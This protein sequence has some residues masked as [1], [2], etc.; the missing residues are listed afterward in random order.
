MET[1]IELF[2]NKIVDLKAKISLFVQQ[3]ESASGTFIFS[4]FDLIN[5]IVFLGDL[6]LNLLKLIVELE[7]QKTILMECMLSSYNLQQ[8]TPT[9]TRP[10]SSN[11]CYDSSYDAGKLKFYDVFIVNLFNFNIYFLNIINFSSFTT[12]S[13]V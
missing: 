3:Y 1:T 8:Q 2:K 11:S 4:L 13:N 10:G 6:K 9:I 12:T 5:N 7:R